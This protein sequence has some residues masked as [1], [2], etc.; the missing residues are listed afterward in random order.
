[1]ATQTSYY[2]PDG[3]IQIGYIIDNKTYKDEAGTQRIDIGSHVPSAQGFY[4]MTETGGVLDPDYNPRA[5]R[6]T[7]RIEK[8]PDSNA[9]IDEIYDAKTK[10][11]QAALQSAYDQNV[12]TLNT[13]RSQIPGVYQDAKNT[14]ASQ[15]EI[16]K[17]NFNEYA[18]ANGLNSGTGGQAQLAFSNTLQGNLSGL[19]KQQAKAT[20][21][22]DLQMANLETTY[23]NNVAAAI[24]Q[25]D[26]E[27]AN[28]LYNKYQTDQAN[29]LALKQ[30]NDSLEYRN[31]TTNYERSLYYADYTG[32][33]SSMSPWW[34]PEAIAKANEKAKKK[35]V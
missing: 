25:G 1:M 7:D 35:I 32:D 17:A 19:D 4:K 11:A 22:M 20:S 9:Y 30:Y 15:G 31:D 12:N 6:S 26:F 13:A 23:K 2:G 21:D 3:S 5:N 24:A 16:Q 8:N 10:A 14:T 34:T 28:A 27:K 18:S 33:Y 29:A